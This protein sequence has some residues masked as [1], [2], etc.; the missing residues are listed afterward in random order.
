MYWDYVFINT[1]PCFFEWGWMGWVSVEHLY[2]KYTIYFCN[3][4]GNN[5]KPIVYHVDRTRDGKTYTSRNIKATQ[6][7]VPIFSMQA[8]FKI[9]ETDPLEHQF[10]MPVVPN[11]EDLISSKE[12]MK[13]RLEWVLFLKVEQVF[14]KCL[15]VKKISFRTF[16]II[17]Y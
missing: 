10:T 15:V 5:E 6:D 12:Y 2:C 8:S 9:D 4:S 11:P 14:K 3:I 1:A 7:G 17:S 13:N 16:D